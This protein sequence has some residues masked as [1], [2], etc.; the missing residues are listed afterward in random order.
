ML[1]SVDT[2]YNTTSGHC[3]SGG[4]NAPNFIPTN[5]TGLQISGGASTPRRPPVP[6]LLRDVVALINIYPHIQLEHSSSTISEI[7]RG[8]GP[9]KVGV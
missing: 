7:A 4:Q 3:S 8:R 2:K 6:K 5:C 9:T 1:L